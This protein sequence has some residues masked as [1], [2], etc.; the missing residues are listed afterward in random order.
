MMSER[1]LQTTA[2][3][4]L[5]QDLPGPSD[6]QS[7]WRVQMLDDADAFARLVKRW[8]LPIRRLC[9]RMTG[10]LHKGEDLAQEAFIRVFAHRKR[11]DPQ[12]K[13]STWLWRIAMNLCQD[14]LRRTN[15]RGESSIDELEEHHPSETGVLIDDSAPPDRMMATEETGDSVRRAVAQL[16]ASL[17]TVVVLRHFENL[18]FREIAEILQI[19]EG[20]VKS[21]MVEAL[22][23][24][25]RRLKPT[26]GDKV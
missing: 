17:R 24:L 8:T 9:V 5:W 20:T 7:M 16:T 12:A 18:K 25:N 6:E 13:F 10:D 21:R 11:F 26:L 4:R 14:E 22:S 19:P 1:L 2:M 3:P 15:R 23:R